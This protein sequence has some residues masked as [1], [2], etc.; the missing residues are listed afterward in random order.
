MGV[1]MKAAGLGVGS[2]SEERL[3]GLADRMKEKDAV[4]CPTLVALLGAETQALEAWREQMGVDTLPEPA[5]QMIRSVVAGMDAVSRHVVNRFAGYGVR[6]LVGQDGNDPAATFTEMRLMEEAGV[7]EAEILR[8][9]TLYPARW[10]GVEDRL[11]AIAPGLEADLLLVNGDPLAD[12]AQMESTF[13]VVQKGR[14]LTGGSPA[15][16]A[17]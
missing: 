11:G 14:V 16:P 8:G 4:L 13:L 12:I 17:R 5:A 15:R 3:R 7:S 1:M 6:M 9:A 2:I 10:L